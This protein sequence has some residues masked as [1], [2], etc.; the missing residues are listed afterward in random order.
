[1]VT[2]APLAFAGEEETIDIDTQS[3]EIE[4]AAGDYKGVMAHDI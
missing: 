1:M 2:N 4:V 3:I